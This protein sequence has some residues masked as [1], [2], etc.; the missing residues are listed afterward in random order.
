MLS[1]HV[2]RSPSLWLHNKSRLFHRNFIRCLYNKQNI[3]CPLVD[4][5]FILSCS[6]RYLTRSLRSL[7]RYRVEHSKIKFISTRGHVIFSISAP[8][9]SRNFCFF[10]RTLSEGL[11]IVISLISTPIIYETKTLFHVTRPPCCINPKVHCMV[12]CNTVWNRFKMAD[13][14][15]SCNFW[16]SSQ[17]SVYMASTTKKKEY[18][19]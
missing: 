14:Q 5:N 7:M 10:Y 4:M 3:T 8:K 9:I 15:L 16:F 1:S 17:Q 18:K 13:E 6:T 19:S 12:L 11:S 2:K